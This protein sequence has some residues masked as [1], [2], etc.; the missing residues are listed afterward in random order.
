VSETTLDLLAVMAHPDDAELWAGGTLA[1]HAVS[2][3]V[4]I[5]LPT[6]EP[7]RTTEAA[8]G[9]AILGAALHWLPSTDLTAAIGTVL[10]EQRPEVVITHPMSDVH[11]DHRALAHAVLAAL[12]DAV[13]RTG[14]PRRLYSCDSYNS[15]GLTGPI[16][17]TTIVDIS[18]TAPQK[19][20]AL[21]AHTSSQP[22]DDH[23]AP[24]AE[25]LGRL[26]GARIGA[27]YA[28][29]FTAIPVLGRLPGAE[30]L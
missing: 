19:M 28:E 5:A 10:A 22:I 2:G 21:A 6:S 7:G 23:F 4:A 24:M 29:A 13:I 25:T 16:T 1:H 26:W 9:A 12:P 14:H 17:A 18:A 8:A 3:P 15:L 11:P 27:T 20:R 30:H